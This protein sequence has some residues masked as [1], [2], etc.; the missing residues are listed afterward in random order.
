[1]NSLGGILVPYL[2]WGYYGL[3]VD[4]SLCILLLLSFPA[5]NLILSRQ[6]APNGVMA[7][8]GAGH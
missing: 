8:C 6:I 1:M 3:T 7:S 2:P 5:R 4:S